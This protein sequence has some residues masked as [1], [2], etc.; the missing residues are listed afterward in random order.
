MELL[1]RQ[2]NL[3]SSSHIKILWNYP[4]QIVIFIWGVLDQDMRYFL[5]R[6]GGGVGGYL[7]LNNSNNEEANVTKMLLVLWL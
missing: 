2:V 4:S 1:P 7:L 5:G 6:L 3:Q